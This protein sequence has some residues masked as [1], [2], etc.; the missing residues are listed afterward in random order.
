MRDALKK[1]N[2]GCLWHFTDK[3]N[4]ESI[5]N[6]G[7]LSWKELERIGIAPTVPGGNTWSHDADKH[8]G[9]D[10][11]V[12]LSFNKDNP[13]LY[14]ATRDKRIT[15][16]VWLQIDL[17]VIGADTRYT[18]DVANKAGVPMLDNKTAIATIDFEALFKYM[19]FGIQG[20]KERKN[21]AAKSEVLVP[22]MI[23]L[24][25]IKGL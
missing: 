1:Y 16:P 24:D 18:N 21:A 14:I 7:L 15:D 12:H 6:H 11:Y 2:V 17:S 22:I 3:K 4:I 25:K 19:D 8:V 9:V 13:M 23:G 5:K 20:N 10:N